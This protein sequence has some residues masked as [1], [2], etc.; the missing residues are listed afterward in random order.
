MIG[1]PRSPS[2]GRLPG[3]RKVHASF[4]PPH[5]AV[6]EM[7]P[8]L[9]GVRPAQGLAR[10]G[11]AC[12]SP[13][14]GY[15]RPASA[16]MCGRVTLTKSAIRDVADELDA[17]VA[18]EDEAL[19]RPRYNVAPSDLHWILEPSGDRRV[20]VPAAWGYFV[21]GARGS[22]APSPSGKPPAP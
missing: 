3:A 5:P 6:G 22:S 18:V 7:E 10:S 1:E 12:R 20:L 4:V 9:L 11:L 2:F 19:Y 15:A 16:S 17:E 21:S 14:S 8:A 13:A